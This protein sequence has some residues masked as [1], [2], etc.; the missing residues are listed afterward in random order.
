MAWFG[1]Q[2]V[3]EN[4]YD[5]L[6]CWGGMAWILEWILNHTQSRP[7]PIVHRFN[8]IEAQA[9]EAFNQAE[10]NGIVESRRKWYQ[11]DVT[12]LYEI[13][14]RSADALVA[15]SHHNGA[16]LDEQRY[17]SPGRIHV[18]PDPLPDDF[19]GRDVSFEREKRIGYCGTWIDRKGKTVM[20]KDLSRFL[21]AFPGWSFSI[22]GVGEGVDPQTEFP[23]DVQDRVEVIPF[24]DRDDLA[25]WYHSLAIFVLPAIYEGSGLVAREAIACGTALVGT[26]VGYAAS[27]E[28]EYSVMHL[29]SLE[30]PALFEAL[31]TL[32]E[33]ESLRR[34][35]AK[36]GY[37]SVQDLR[38]NDAVD[39]LESIYQELA[40]EHSS[41]KAIS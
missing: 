33:E 18:I 10:G 11:L 2:R 13:G 15:P 27:L 17:V 8:G 16:F 36:N 25:K 34:Q 38:W 31:S 37:Q 4:D 14:Y 39:R 9:S 22:V 41:S 19:L 28:H 5:L 7:F 12:P 23:S 3:R 29:S 20:V 26:A 40:Q 21:R 35:I 24:L 1:V 30:S 32:A 6:E